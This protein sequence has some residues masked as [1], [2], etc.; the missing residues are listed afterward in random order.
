MSVT[1]IM[2]AQ[3]ALNLA[4]MTGA[5]EIT[6]T[7]SVTAATGNYFCA[8]HAMTATVVAAQTNVN[9]AVNAD[10]TKITSI[11]ANAVLHGKWST[12]TLASGQ[13]IGY[14]AKG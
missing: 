14:Y 11:P 5:K 13:M 8:L 12:V 7:A 3:A 6:G 2:A 10:L 1:E 4:G 9:D